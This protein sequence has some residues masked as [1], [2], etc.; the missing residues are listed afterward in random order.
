MPYGSLHAG[1][2]T[3]G[4]GN[5]LTIDGAWTAASQTCANLGSVT[6]ADI[7][8]GT[9]DGATVGVS[10]HSTGKFTTCDATTDFTIGGL[11]VTDGNIADTGT[12]AIVPVD[13]CTIALG[14]DAG[15]DFNVGSG[16]LIVE[17]DTG[18]VG[19]GIVP[20]GGLAWD[21]DPKVLQIDH[22]SLFGWGEE[23]YLSANAVM[24]SDNTYFRITT[25]FACSYVLKTDTGDHIWKTA[26]DTSGAITWIEGMRLQN[27]GELQLFG[28]GAGQSIKIHPTSSGTDISQSSG[29]Y[30]RFLVGGGA[31]EVLRI[32]ANGTL[33][34]SPTLDISDERLKE[35][36]NTVSG[37]LEKINQLD[38][39]TFTWK[40]MA[41]M[42]AGVQYGLIAQEVEEILPE[43]VIQDES[44]RVLD[45]DGNVKPSNE[46]FLETDEYCKEIQT[47]GLIPILIEAVKELSAKVTA[48]ENAK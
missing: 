45:K 30:T 22:F 29:I 15:D 37:A 27:S 4:S 20:G 24:T 14:T 7:N 12:L 42:P 39:R 23:G 47:S 32:L 5:T 9:I 33:S 8:G 31:T 16:K 36:I 26:A 13:G 6:T 25:S 2:I 35:N 1:T 41:K 48:L 43:L 28:D 18:N 21:S 34:G 38:G 11:V 19:I 10:S 46:E 17:G 3:P 44:I 40:T